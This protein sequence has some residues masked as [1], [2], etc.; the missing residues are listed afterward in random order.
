M[1]GVSATETQGNHALSPFA[2][3]SVLSP[4]VPMALYTQLFT[5]ES[6]ACLRGVMRGFQLRQVPRPTHTVC[7]PRHPPSFQVSASENV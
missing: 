5:P 4:S 7:W 3:K 1:R 6:V 2:T